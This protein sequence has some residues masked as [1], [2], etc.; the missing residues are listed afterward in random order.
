VR[1]HSRRKLDKL[2]GYTLLEVLV[3][4]AIIAVL[5]GALMLSAGAGGG[6]HKLE[7]ETTR[8]LRVLE[9]A[10]DQAV[11]EARFIGFGVGTESYAGYDF[12]DSGWKVVLEKGPLG[13]YQLPDGIALSVPDADEKLLPTVPEKPQFVCAPTGELGS[14]DLR[15]ALA[16]DAD[17][18]RIELDEQG[19]PHSRISTA[20]AP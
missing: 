7:E 14:L 11:I 1:T 8:L 3:V 16:G 15:I 4:V 2:L 20:A 9:L 10:C 17:A 5:S 6:V 19:R 18:W 12:S 13:I